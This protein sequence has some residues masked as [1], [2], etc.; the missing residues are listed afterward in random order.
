M[1]I[2][3]IDIKSLL[4]YA[5]DAYSS[6]YGE[7]YRSIIS[8]KINN[9]IIISYR[10]VDE[11]SNYI[12]HL[13]RCKRRE[14]GVL[15]LESIGEDIKKYKN[16]NY[17][18]SF[19][20]EVE[21]LL[22]NYFGSFVVGFNEI[23][24]DHYIP[25]YL[26][27]QD[28]NM[29]SEKNTSKLK[30]IN[31]LR[32]NKYDE[33]T[34]DNFESFTK[35]EEYSKLLTRINEIKDVYER[36]FSEYKEW[37][38]QF[39]SYND[40]I[41]SEMKRK[42]EI[43]EEKKDELFHEIFSYLPSSVKEV[44]LKENKEKVCNIIF[45]VFDISYPTL[46]ENFSDE[47]M[48]E[49]TSSEVSLYDKSWIIYRQNI[50]LNGVGIKTP[51]DNIL[52]NYSEEDV[53]KY[54][55]FLKQDNVR[56]LIPSGE[57]IKYFTSIREQK[58]EEGLKEYYT[59]RNDFKDALKIFGNNSNAI[60]PIY[61]SFKNKSVCVLGGGATRNDNEFISVMFYTIRTFGLGC[62]FFLF[63]HEI[64][65]IIDQSLDGCGFESIVDYRNDGRKNS[66]NSSYRKYERINET[67]NDM[68][69]MEAV[70]FLNNQGIY[71][72]E[73]KE[74]ALCD[75][76]NINTFLIVKNLL[77]PLVEKFRKQVI[78]A[79]VNTNLEELTEYIGEDNFDELVD[80]VNKV[81][82]LC[83]KGLI[84]KIE[85]DT[86][87]DIV[88][89]YLEQLEKVKQIYINIDNY[90]KNICY[91]NEIYGSEIHNKNK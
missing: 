43:L 79:K 87:D 72:I 58:Y 34:E 14:F 1:D 41:D 25:F 63:M 68:F 17:L 37:L 30:L 91:Y 59:T 86:Q 32:N 66:Y 29:N 49:L 28:N 6:V 4:P 35:T 65:H 31:Y 67:I 21:N 90:Y 44:L 55:E 57:T 8:E 40:Y 76:S 77:K 70:Q 48:S 36:L 9:A 2:L 84:S 12:Y 23:I 89:E 85:T 16:D 42:R 7:E 47:K 81:D 45:G 11:L 26:F 22:E 80:V 38:G 5:I 50:Y 54:L 53:L 88:N 13:K 56:E 62:L 83:K 69:A 24:K 52:D 46:I 61:N 74:Y 64:G 78:K 60:S 19:N 51:D 39:S 73:P 10:D 20:P 15:F 27:E 18:E 33:I 75:T 82:N 3:N 71:L